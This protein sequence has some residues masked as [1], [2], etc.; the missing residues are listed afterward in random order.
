MRQKYVKSNSYIEHTAGGSD[1]R[2]I[3]F[4]KPITGD[5]EESF[6]IDASG[7]V[8]KRDQ[9]QKQ[10][11]QSHTPQGVSVIKVTNHSEQAV[12]I[13]IV[14]P[15]GKSKGKVGGRSR[16]SMRCPPGAVALQYTAENKTETIHFKDSIPVGTTEEVDVAGGEIRENQKKEQGE[17]KKPNL[18]W[19]MELGHTSSSA[20][21]RQSLEEHGG[22]EIQVANHTGLPL[23]FKL[24][25]RNGDVKGFVRSVFEHE[26]RISLKSLDR[27]LISSNDNVARKMTQMK[28]HI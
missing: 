15:H 24:I 23:E 5:S 14:Y 16:M 20:K 18:R 9:I 13:V 7:N 1:V 11:V 22:A 6:V 4:D 8:K 17:Y 12:D 27:F 26:L 19:S 2:R 25:F 10:T 3:K 28:L 21:K